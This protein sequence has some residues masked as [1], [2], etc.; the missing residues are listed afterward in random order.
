MRV[1]G[2]DIAKLAVQYATANER[3][4]TTL[5]STAN[6]D[7]IRKNIAWTDEPMDIELLQEV[8]EI[9]K[10]IHNKSWISGRPEYNEKTYVDN[11][12]RGKPSMK[13]IVCEQIEQFKYVEVAGAK[14]K[15][16]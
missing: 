10:P 3:I 12:D 5:V 7:N 2:T 4:P 15:S 13:A 14:C 11:L 16:R 1:K 9:L 8:L 6:P